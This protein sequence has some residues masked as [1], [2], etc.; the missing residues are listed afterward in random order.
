VTEATRRMSIAGDLFVVVIRGGVFP[1]NEVLH[2]AGPLDE[3]VRQRGTPPS[4]DR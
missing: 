4:R 2:I 1:V 3:L